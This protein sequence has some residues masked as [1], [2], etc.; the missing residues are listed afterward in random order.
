MVSDIRHV[1]QTELQKEIEEEIGVP[2]SSDLL[3]DN[4]ANILDQSHQSKGG[5]PD[6]N[7]TCTSDF[8]QVPI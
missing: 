1:N 5:E 4:N 3:K 8:Y 7:E 6:L 2:D